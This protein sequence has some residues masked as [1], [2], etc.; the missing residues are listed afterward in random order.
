MGHIFVSYKTEDRDYAATL[1]RAL[2]REGW[3]VWWDRSIPA[4][5]RYDDVIEQAIADAHCV[6][7][8]WTSRS[9]KSDWV[10]NEAQEGA[11]RQ[12][13]VPVRVEDVRIPL[14]FRR[15]QAA[16]LIG[17]K[18]DASAPAFRRLVADI[19][20]MVPEPDS[21]AAENDAPSPDGAA[22]PRASE[23]ASTTGVAEV[24]S[25]GDDASHTMRRPSR[26][27]GGQPP[28]EAT[29]ARRGGF[30]DWQ[31]LAGR[32]PRKAL[33]I[34]AAAAIVLMVVI[35]A[36]RTPDRE[37]PGAAAAS[38]SD[39]ES[40]GQAES[41][42]SEARPPQD[43]DPGERSTE[44][45]APQVAQAAV[46]AETGASAP[47][48][49]VESNLA[50]TGSEDPPPGDVPEEPPARNRPPADVPATALSPSPPVTDRNGQAGTESTANG[51]GRPGEASGPVEVSAREMET[52]VLDRVSPLYPDAARQSGLEGTVALRTWIAADGTVTAVEHLRG[53][54]TLGRAASAAVRQWRYRPWTAP[55]SDEALDVVTT[56]VVRFSIVPQA[57]EAAADSP[58]ASAG[59]PGGIPAPARSVFPPCSAPRQFSLGSGEIEAFPSST[60]TL[61]LYL[62]RL[63]PNLANGGGMSAT[64][65]W[66]RTEVP[67]WD[68]AD[69]DSRQIAGRLVPAT[70]GSLEPGSYTRFGLG[71]RDRQGTALGSNASIEVQ[72]L[73]AE[74]GSAQLAVCVR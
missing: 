39:L 58:A 55:E 74:G 22:P 42:D 26:A 56:V 53:D 34:G 5:K 47:P 7:V 32:F 72:F 9:I 13:L 16:D 10:L 8:L 4:G 25:T 68:Q 27:A 65:Y 20:A 69:I 12:I 18:G 29:E 46:S 43:T 17:W 44:G 23:P 66:V 2:E 63:S 61:G 38:L 40:F 41:S 67:W 60:D 57:V 30:A 36:I 50:E 49:N 3:D 28:I 59:G 14:A 45:P 31:R 48:P 1:A 64:L 33:W 62:D 35:V 21:A 54:E 15:I 51:P 70:S 73:G 71:E 52:R 37:E 24:S 19:R 6:V 11:D